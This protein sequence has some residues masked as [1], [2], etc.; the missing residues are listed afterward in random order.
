[1]SI[2]RQKRNHDTDTGNR[3]KY[4]KEQDSE[5]FFIQMVHPK[6]PFKNSLNI[7]WRFQAQESFEPQQRA[8]TPRL[9]AGF[10]KTRTTMAVNCSQQ[11]LRRV[12]LLTLEKKRIDG[13]CIHRPADGC[14]RGVLD[15]R[16]R[17][18]RYRNIC[19]INIDCSQRRMTSGYV[20]GS[21][22]NAQRCLLILNSTSTRRFRVLPSIVSLVSR[23]SAGPMPIV[24]IFN[25][26]IPLP[27]R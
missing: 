1:M 23:G 5:N 21:R 8:L 14:C 6:Y 20:K 9:A 22:N 12:I 2:Y 4:G 13:R 11:A 26:E 19:R 3:R 18:A 25:G 16:M 7:I 27:A 24:S 17:P 15:H 10:F